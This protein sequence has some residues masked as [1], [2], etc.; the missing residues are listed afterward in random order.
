MIRVQREDIDVA[1]ALAALVDGRQDTGAL[2]LFVGLVRD[3]A[4]GRPVDALTLEHY[5]GMTEKVLGAIDAEARRRWPLNATVIIHRYG[6]LMPGD[7]IVLV[8]VG[9]AHRDAAFDACRFLVD[10][11]KTEAPLW[12][13]EEGAGE[14]RWVAARAADDAAAG[15]WST[16]ATVRSRR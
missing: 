11:L 15:R 16:A 4:E 7:R 13:L 10:T 14:R 6:R 9:A 2:A 5:P 3:M 1:G 8:A 12:K